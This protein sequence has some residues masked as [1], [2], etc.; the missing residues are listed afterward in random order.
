MHSGFRVIR[1][2]VSWNFGLRKA[3][4]GT[5]EPSE[6]GVPEEERPNTFSSAMRAPVSR[7]AALGAAF[8]ICKEGLHLFIHIFSQSV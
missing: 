2:Q 4:W 5:C 6:E 8:Y 7:G 3:V 1:E